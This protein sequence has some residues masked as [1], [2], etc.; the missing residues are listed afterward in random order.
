MATST[1]RTRFKPDNSSYPLRLALPPA[2]TWRRRGRSPDPSR[3]RPD[4]MQGCGQVVEL[5]LI[6]SERPQN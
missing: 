2:P 4:L 6:Q 5:R 1:K 3:G